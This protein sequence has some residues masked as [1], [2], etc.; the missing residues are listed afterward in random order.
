MGSLADVAPFSFTDKDG[1]HQGIIND[2]FELI[3]EK[4]GLKFSTQFDDWYK[5]LK[6]LRDKQIDVI[7]GA[8]YTGERSQFALYS[9][10][11][12]E[13]LDYFF[14]RSDVKANNLSDL[15]GKR[16]AMPKGFAHGEQLKKYFPKIEIVTVDTIGDAVDAVL[17]KRAELLF[18]AYAT[19]PYTLKINA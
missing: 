3:S 11:F 7:G 6:K 9:T 4:T 18:N 16:V 10:P 5:L 19:L 13:V 17:E 1:K 14:I 2:Y 15:N 8:Y 12:F